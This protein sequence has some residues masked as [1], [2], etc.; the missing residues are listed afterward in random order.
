MF[1]NPNTY[2]FEAP[3]PSAQANPTK[4]RACFSGVRFSRYFVFYIVFFVRSFYCL[5]F[6]PQLLITIWYLQMYLKPIDTPRV[7]VGR[8]RQTITWP[9][10]KTNNKMAN[11]NKTDN[12]MTKRKKTN[13]RIAKRNR[14]AMIWSNEK[15]QFRLAISLSVFSLGHVIV[16]RFRFALLLSVFFRLATLLSIV[17]VWP[18][19]CLSFDLQLLITPLV[20]SNLS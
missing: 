8:K 2:L 20:S 9:S 10:E 12:K 7:L 14:Q 5:V 13:N 3:G 16:C 15:R 11:L 19:Y 6:D 1:G 17:F 18:F 4:T